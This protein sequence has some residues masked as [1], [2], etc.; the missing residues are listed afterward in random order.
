[1]THRI[2]FAASPV[3]G[4]FMSSEAF[5]RLLAGPYGSG[6]TTTV[7]MELLRR[8]CE[9]WP[10]PDGIRR[11]RFAICRQTL[12][13]LKNTVL[14]DAV[15]WFHPIARWKVSES[16]M[17]FDF[18]DVRSEWLLLPLETP[19]DQRRLLSLQLTGAMLNEAIETDVD[20]V[21]PIS[22]R[23][24]RY[25]SAADG[26]CKWY[27]LVAD[28]NMPSEGSPWHELMENPDEE[29]VVFIQPGGLEPNAENLN[30]LLQTPDTLKLPLDH[31]HRIAQG[32]IYYERL[33]RN[34]NKDWVDRFVNAKYA[35]DPS[36]TAVFKDS[37]N[38]RFHVVDD[39]E[40][41]NATIVVGQDFG[42][43]PVSVLLQMD[44]MGRIL[45]LEEL[46][47]EDIGLQTQ[48]PYLR[49]LLN[50]ERFAGKRV[51]LVG[52]PSGD[53]K[54]SYDERTAFDI[55]RQH[56]FMIVRAPTN[57]VDPRIRAVENYLLQQRAG[58]P[59][60][61]FSRRGCPK[62]IAAMGGGYRYTY[63]HL[64]VSRALPDKDAHS[65]LAD[66]LQYGVMGLTG[67]TALQ[68]AR[69]LARKTGG[70]AGRQRMS[71]AGWT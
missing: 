12:T 2:D 9:Q 56:G 37:F 23:C 16:T 61:V 21:G 36:G 26:G 58:G 7:L 46:W 31:P 41:L 32:R 30:Y 24:G 39:I 15:A 68:I 11:T 13:Q 66:A 54:G 59:A 64:N 65:H 50:Q 18:R 57:L 14:K 69:R 34:R 71:A 17:H 51:C 44:H 35:P 52:D 40:P 45:V 6:K 63:S 1:M 49:A 42:R 20:L 3:G 8:A 4:Q 28:T 22:S 47:A 55:C 27:G 67:T 43:N 33:A 5:F 60:L 38:R 53:D 10:G 70:S 29:T 19:E 62:L 25:P 48:L